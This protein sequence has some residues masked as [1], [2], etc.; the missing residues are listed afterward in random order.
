MPVYEYRCTDCRQVV[1]QRRPVEERNWS[2]RH[3]CESGVGMLNRL[4]TPTANISIPSSFR[5]RRGWNLPP[6]DSP[7]WETM[8]AEDSMR[9]EKETTFH[10]YMEAQK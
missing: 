8:V 6:K 10:D 1:E 3:D 5:M 9:P 7:R 4:F 2:A